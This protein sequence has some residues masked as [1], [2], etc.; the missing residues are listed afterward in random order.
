MSLTQQAAPPRSRATAVYI[1]TKYIHTFFFVVLPSSQTKYAGLV[2]RCNAS[3]DAL[4]RGEAELARLGASH[5]RQRADIAMMQTTNAALRSELSKFS[6]ATADLVA[7]KDNA[8][9]DLENYK[10]ALCGE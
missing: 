4:K 7:A 10:R 3:E 6:A 1:H 5:T 9:R 8:L 2:S